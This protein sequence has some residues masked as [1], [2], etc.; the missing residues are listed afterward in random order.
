MDHIKF[1][2]TAHPFML[3]LERMRL[4]RAKNTNLQRT[5]WYYVQLM[6]ASV[7]YKYW[8]V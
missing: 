1:C 5:S 7:L 4:N 6:N 2:R 3:T 8:K